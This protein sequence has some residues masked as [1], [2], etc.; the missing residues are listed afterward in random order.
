[1]KW[2]KERELPLPGNVYLTPQDSIASFDPV[3]GSLSASPALLSRVRLSGD[4]LFQSAAVAFG[5]RALALVLSGALSD[6]AE[7]VVEIAR[8]GGRVLAQSYSSAEFADMPR[9]AMKQSRIGMAFDPSAL[10]HVVVS[11]VMA[12]GASE[13]FRV[14]EGRTLRNQW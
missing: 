8:L 2:V 3:D 7:G 11:L 6:G 12:P 1:M 10:A 14:G 13:W 9:A 4:S 5:N